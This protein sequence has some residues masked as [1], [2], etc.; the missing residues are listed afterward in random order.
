MDII[1]LSSDHWDAPLWTNKQHIMSRLA[2]AGHS[3]LYVDP[4]TG[5]A[6]WWQGRARLPY[7]RKRLLS[8]TEERGSN[9]WVF[10]PLA[11]PLSRLPAID[12]L[13]DPVRMWLLRNILNVL[14]FS[15]PALWVYDP[16]EA[17]LAEKLPKSILIYDCVDEFSEFPSYSGRKESVRQQERTLL[18][19]ADVVITVSES[20]CE[21]KRQFNPN[22]RLV[23]NAADA[24]HFAQAMDP[25]TQIPARI[26]NVPKPIIG[27]AGALSDYK[28]DF[29][30]L[31]SMAQKHPQWQ[32]VLI[33]PLQDDDLVRKYA[34][35]G[36]RN[37]HLVGRVAYEELPHYMKAFDVCIIPYECNDYTRHL[38][39]LKFFEYMATGKP[40]VTANLPSLMSYRDV[41]RVAQDRDDFLRQVA[42]ALDECEPNLIQKRLEL[43]RQNTWETRINRIMEIVQDELARKRQEAE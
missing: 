19:L 31:T 7:C 34:L 26:A 36:C 10:S 23:P 41:V 9:L 17:D 39:T 22:T 21:K 15:S 4:P 1:C 37:V 20:L 12:R 43:A 24:E 18:R 35:D 25:Q 2:K 8:W 38:R 27:F 42:A 5:L 40:I 11:I 28:L 16:K 29:P 32:I 30:L 33:G 3:V 13:N 6:D 14:R